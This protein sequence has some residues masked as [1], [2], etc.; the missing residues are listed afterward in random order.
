MVDVS[1]VLMF[2]G[3]VG[4]FVFLAGIRIIRPFEK[5]LHERFG[6]FIGEK[7]QG[8]KWIIPLID[9][10]VKVDITENMVDVPPQQIITKDKLNASVDAMVYFKVNEP[11]KAIYK[12]ENYRHQIV[13]LSR[14]TLRN[15]VGTM[16]L[17]DANEGRGEINEQLERELDKHTNAWGIEIVRVELQRIEPPANVQAAMNEVVE[18]EN[19]K[20]SA[21]NFANAVETEADGK[22]RAAVKEADGRKQS[23]ILQ[24]EGEA[25]AI[26]QV[27]DAR[28]KEIE[29]VNQSIQKNFKAE[30]QDYK[31]LETTEIALQNG[32]KY[33]IDPNSNITNVMTEMSGVTPI[34]TKKK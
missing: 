20:T 21:V 10:L 9:R 17:T 22:R 12:A 25:N 1:L 32:S 28:A 5:G 26:K 11:Q 33:V 27:A 2:F 13:S 8:F 30:A 19:K 24:A 34:Q 31:K 16:S 7:E 14:T 3:I 23:T 6:K 29:V 4:F 18:A 15:I